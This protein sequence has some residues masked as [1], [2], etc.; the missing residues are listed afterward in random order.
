MLYSECDIVVE[1]ARSRDSKTV[2]ELE[3][4]LKLVGCMRV[5]E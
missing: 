5:A 3:T 2:A 1:E 4:Y